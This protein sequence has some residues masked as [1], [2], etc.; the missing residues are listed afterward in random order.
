M[1]ADTGADDAAAR[2]ERADAIRRLRDAR[3]TP[4]GQPSGGGLDDVEL[5]Q[6]DEQ[7]PNYVDLID[8][9]M[10]DLRDG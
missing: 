6:A 3:N 10:R 1:P 9:K 5:E 2:K 7:G 4:Q 8:R